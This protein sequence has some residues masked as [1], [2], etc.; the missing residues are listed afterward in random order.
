MTAYGR[1]TLM[2]EAVKLGTRLF[3]A[4]TGLCINNLN[5]AVT[6]DLNF[7]ILTDSLVF[8]HDKKKYN[9]SLGHFLGMFSTFNT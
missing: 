4:D 8:L 7:F 6:N 9:T 5:R 1:L 3:Y 2:R